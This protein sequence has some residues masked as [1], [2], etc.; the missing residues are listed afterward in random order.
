MK[1]I[2]IF[3]ASA[4]FT[5][6]GAA[7]LT[8][9]NPDFQASGNNSDPAGWLVSETNAG[10]VSS[11]YIWGST[12]NVLAF[13]GSGARAQQSFPTTEVTADSHGFFN[14]TFDS[15]WR[16]CNVPTATGFQVEFALVNVTDGTTLGTAVYQFPLPLAAISNTY[17][18]IGTGNRVAISY[19]STKSSLIGDTLALRITASGSPNQGGN[20]FANTGWIDNISVTAGDRSPA[21][22]WSF[23]P[24]NRLQEIYVRSSLDLTET[25]GS[26]TWVSRPNFGDVM[27]NGLNPPYLVAASQAALEPGAG[28]FALSLWSRRTSDDTAAAGLLDA[29]SSSAASGW[30][31]F[32]QANDTLRLRLDDSLGNTINADTA[33]GQLSLNE[34]QK[35]I[36]NVDRKANRVRFFINGSEVAPIGGVNISVLTGSIVPDQNLFLGTLNGT[37]A[38]KGQIDDVAIFNRILTTQEIAA[39]HANGGTPILSLYPKNEPLPAVVASPEP[40][41][42]LRASQTVS[43]ASATGSLIRYTMDGSDPTADSP[44]YST[45][46]SI[47]ATTTVKARVSDG[48]RLGAITEATYLRIPENPPNVLVIVGDDVGFNDLGCYGAVTLSTPRIDALSY[49]GQR[50]TQFTTTGPGDAASQY[51]LL[52]GRL[53]RRGGMPSIVPPNSMGWDS[54]EWTLTEAFR[55]AGYQTGF[56]GAWHLGG[57]PGSHPNDQGFAGFYGL[58][59]ATGLSPAPLWMENRATVNPTPVDALEALTTRLENEISAH[60]AERFFFI[61]QPPA[62]PSAGTSLLGTYGNWIEALDAATG[63][64]LDRLQSTGVA[65]HTLVIFLS[66]GGANRN[67]TTYPTGSNGQFRDGSGSTWEGGVRTPFI[68]RWPGVIPVGDNKA[69]LWLPDLHRTLATLIDGYQPAAHPLDGVSRPDVLLGV[70]TRP[71][72][73][74]TLFLHRHTGAA[75][76]PQ[77]IRRGKWKLHLSAVNTDP[78]NTATTTTPLLFDL[79]LDPSERINRAG[80]ETSVLA[81]LQQSAAAHEAT[82]GTPIPQL[83]AARAAF[84]G[85]VQTSTAQLTETTAAFNFTRPKDSLNDHYILQTGNDLNGWDDLVIDPFVI[86]TP[87]LQPDTENIQVTVPLEAL[88]GGSSRFFVRLKSVRP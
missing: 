82:F 6:A 43:L 83:P 15:G 7:P 37:D 78:G 57:Q 14:V 64:L 76:V 32:Y 35:I 63:R 10:N 81:S 67:A 65:N 79:L 9:A 27:A 71:D 30:Q 22:H 70:R 16:G 21:A 61:F 13:W 49:Q 86:V 77:T 19:D 47:T 1:P 33:A 36:V 46:L 84:L 8:L 40:G 12:S 60:A 24:P 39:I 56:M 68:A 26:S 42:I 59:W 69:V 48:T 41:S 75:Y 20:N 58:P 28:D 54:R 62:L 45:P 66:D 25:N 52:T 55:K 85:P 80:T 88:G 34:W 87:G 29:L 3:I 38:A 53:A 2:L 50:F 44:V 18:V 51:A 4:V 74:S 17:T 73:G 11:L 31:L 72:D 5:A 23:D